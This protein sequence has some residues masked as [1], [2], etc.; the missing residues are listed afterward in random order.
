MKKDIIPKNIANSYPKQCPV[1]GKKCIAV[2][3]TWKP[4]GRVSCEFVHSKENKTCKKT[5]NYYKIS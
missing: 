3:R 4:T 1:C 5:Y 2:F